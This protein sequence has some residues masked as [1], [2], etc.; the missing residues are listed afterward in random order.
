[1]LIIFVINIIYIQHFLNEFLPIKYLENGNCANNI[2]I[3]ILSPKVNT[4]S[5]TINTMGIFTN[6]ANPLEIYSLIRGCDK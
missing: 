1:M 3:P 4:V 6:G 2:A 5:T